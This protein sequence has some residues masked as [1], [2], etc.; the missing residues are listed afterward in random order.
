MGGRTIHKL[1]LNTLVK[2][3]NRTILHQAVFI[4][5]QVSVTFEEII[6]TCVGQ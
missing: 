6:E 1:T 5:I 2:E 4:V 3:K